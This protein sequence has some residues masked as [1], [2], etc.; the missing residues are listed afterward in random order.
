LESPQ[1]E[2]ETPIIP[3]ASQES[4]VFGNL[5]LIPPAS[6]GIRPI[7]PAVKA[8]VDPQVA[9]TV[10]TISRA[11]DPRG[12]RGNGKKSETSPDAPIVSEIT[13]KLKVELM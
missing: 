8:Q 2:R 3:A 5:D 13:P 12:I 4:T 9:D 11:G 7:V 10:S 1:I 6:M